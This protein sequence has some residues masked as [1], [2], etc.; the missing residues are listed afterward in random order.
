MMIVSGYGG[1]RCL[2][3]TI[4][5][6]VTGT[7]YYCSYCGLEI[8]PANYAS[9]PQVEPAPKQKKVHGV[10]NSYDRKREWW[11]HA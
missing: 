5:G 3:V 11:R 2:T 1:C 6:A 4:A 7:N 10:Y 9:K 8:V